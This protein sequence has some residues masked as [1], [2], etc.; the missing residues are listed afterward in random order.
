M[1]RR[2]DVRSVLKQFSVDEQKMFVYFESLKNKNEF[3]K[4][5]FH[6]FCW[7]VVIEKKYPRESDIHFYNLG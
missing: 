1:M 5:F 2:R 6:I 4:S 7:W 3:F